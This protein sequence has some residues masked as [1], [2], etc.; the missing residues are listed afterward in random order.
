MSL[1]R[2]GARVIAPFKYACRQFNVSGQIRPFIGSL[3]VTTR[4]S[5]QFC[6]DG[7]ALSAQNFPSCVQSRWMREGHLVRELARALHKVEEEGLVQHFAVVIHRSGL[8][9]ELV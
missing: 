6:A 1:P 2:K 4:A 5:W 8:L 7:S 9:R 3:E